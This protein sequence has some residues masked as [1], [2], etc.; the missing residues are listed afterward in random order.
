[1]IGGKSR[2][3]ALRSM[4]QTER[5]RGHAKA[6]AAFRLAALSL[7][8]APFAPVAD[9]VVRRRERPRVGGMQQ[10]SGVREC[11]SKR[12]A[13]SGP[14][15][16]PRSR[17]S[18][19]TRNDERSMHAGRVRRNNRPQQRGLA[20]TGHIDDRR[21]RRHRDDARRSDARTKRGE[22]RSLRRAEPSDALLR[23]VIQRMM[24]NA[25]GRRTRDGVEA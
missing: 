5:G 18:R 23:S 24:Q 10:R 21:V 11:L 13:A 12:S 4:V 14:R 17:V 9:L 22:Q 6:W 7:W 1:M 2:C 8:N 3:T 25:N 19:R 16:V 20:R 15:C